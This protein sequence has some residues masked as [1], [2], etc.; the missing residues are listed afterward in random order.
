[1]QNTSGADFASGLNVQAF[2]SVVRKGRD[3]DVEQYSAFYPPLINPRV[4]D[5][6]LAGILKRHGIT[7]VF[8]CGLAAD[9]CVSS[10]AMDAVREGFMTYI[11]DEG[12]RAVDARKWEEEKHVCQ[13]EIR[14]GVK[15]VHV[16]GPDL[17]R[18]R[19]LG[20]RK[21]GGMKGEGVREALDHEEWNKGL[22]VADLPV[23]K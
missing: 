3:R 2:D 13:G 23:A 19:M 10:T 20:E 12:T 11:V 6:G 21:E 15:L 8:V 7:D 18:V 1:M 9:Y 14:P 4:G 5:S 16:G 17:E 22:R